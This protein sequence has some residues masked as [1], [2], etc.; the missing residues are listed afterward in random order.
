MEYH[1]YDSRLNVS[2][3][4]RWFITCFDDLDE[5]ALST[6]AGMGM[7][8]HLMWGRQNKS[9]YIAANTVIIRLVAFTSSDS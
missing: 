3:L 8:D 5:D 6:H 1:T 7:S 2:D 4:I 9:C